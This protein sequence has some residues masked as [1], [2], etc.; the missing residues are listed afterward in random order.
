MCTPALG[1]YNYIPQE[2]RAYLRNYGY[3]FSK[4]ACEY[5]VSLMYRKNAATGRK[6]KIEPYTKDAAEELL[7]KYGVKLDNNT[8]YNFVYVMNMV[9]ADMWK[10][11]V[12]DEMHLCRAV[13]DEID[14]VDGTPDDIFR[15]WMTKLENKGIPVPWEDII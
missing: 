14:D 1:S 5:A 12:E 3:S 15:C 6:E 11:G 10:S 7:K 4:R 2:M 8:G 9:Y 13:K